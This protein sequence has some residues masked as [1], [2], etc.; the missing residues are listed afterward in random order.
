MSP[1]E[2][3]RLLAV[4]GSLAAREAD[5]LPV[6]YFHVVF[7]LILRRYFAVSIVSGTYYSRS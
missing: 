2:T 7:T 1:N 4:A 6:G 3:R 5:L